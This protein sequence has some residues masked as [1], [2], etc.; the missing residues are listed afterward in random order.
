MEKTAFDP[1]SRRLC[2]D[3]NCI[4]LIG[5]DGR[6]KECGRSTD[7]KPAL[8]GKVDGKVDDKVDDNDEVSADGE[9]AAAASEPKPAGAGAFDPNRK[10]CPDG[11][12]TGVIGP[13]G[14]C[15]ECG[16]RAE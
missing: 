10:L 3:G 14:T 16:Q 6:C 5:P 15:R 13:D 7:G 12:C 4:G 2:P 9:A 1:G 11:N 8:V